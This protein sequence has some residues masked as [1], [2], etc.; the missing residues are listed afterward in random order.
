MQCDTSPLIQEKF[1]ERRPRPNVL[2]SE[3]S[4]RVHSKALLSWDGHS[5]GGGG[6]QKIKKRKIYR[7]KESQDGVCMVVSLWKAAI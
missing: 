7:V 5:S 2:C 3:D 1:V 4:S 6:G